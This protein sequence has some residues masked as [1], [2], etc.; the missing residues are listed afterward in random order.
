[1][2]STT[3]EIEVITDIS[4]SFDSYTGKISANLT[5]KK[6]KILD[7]KDADAATKDVV[8]FISQ[9][10]VTKSAYS[11]NSHNFNNSKR[12]IWTLAASDAYAETVFTAT[13]HSGG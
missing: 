8:S 11:E 5:K 9:E 13:P 6:V 2:P 12:N 4:F 10:V 1:M 3:K 7:E